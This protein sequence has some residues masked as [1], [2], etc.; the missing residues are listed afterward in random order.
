MY[1]TISQIRFKIMMLKSSLCDY[2]NAYILGFRTTKIT[3]AG[4][5]DPAKQRDERGTGVIFKNFSPFTEYICGI[6][7]MKVDD[8]Q[9]IYVVMSMYNLIKYSDNYSI[10]SGR[11]MTIFPS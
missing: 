8:G 7:N 4:A 6:N 1:S 5:D 11:F 3:W 2:S 9:K 10:T